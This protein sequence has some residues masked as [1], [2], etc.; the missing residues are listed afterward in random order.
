M[1]FYPFKFYWIWQI[2]QWTWNVEK[3]SL[4]WVYL[5]ENTSCLVNDNSKDWTPVQDDEVIAREGTTASCNLSAHFL[6]NAKWLG[7]QVFHLSARNIKVFFM[8]DMTTARKP[9]IRKVIK[10]KSTCCK[11]VCVFYL[12]RHAKVIWAW[13]DELQVSP[14]ICILKCTMSNATV[15]VQL[16]LWKAK[17]ICRAEYNTTH[18][19]RI[20]VTN[21][22]KTIERICWLI[23]VTRSGNGSC[24]ASACIEFIL[25]QDIRYCEQI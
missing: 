1:C 12:I 23:L 19:K 8:P 21:V 7:R 14:L 6:L 15:Q 3:A 13:T 2:V 17:I 22:V 24:P 11:L 9:F 10:K 25:W 20:E 18:E 5:L 4:I 16:L